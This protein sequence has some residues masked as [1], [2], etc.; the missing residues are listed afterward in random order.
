MSCTARRDRRAQEVLADHIARAD[1]DDLEGDLR[2]NFDPDV[3]VL[4]SRGILRGHEGVRLGRAAAHRPTGRVRLSMRT[5]GRYGQ[6]E[7]RADGPDGPVTGVE[8]FIVRKGRVVVHA[9]RR[10]PAPGR[11]LSVHVP[12]AGPDAGQVGAGPAEASA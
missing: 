5:V 11:G 3:V 10:V 12:L 6:I 2:R 1:R 4:T 9:L 8:T 7:W